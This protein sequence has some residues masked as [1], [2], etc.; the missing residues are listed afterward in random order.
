LSQICKSSRLWNR[1]FLIHIPPPM[2]HFSSDLMANSNVRNLASESGVGGLRSG[3]GALLGCWRREVVQGSIDGCWWRPSADFSRA[4]ILHCKACTELNISCTVS[5]IGCMKVNLD[6]NMV[7]WSSVILVLSFNRCR[8][9]T[10]ANS[11][12]LL[13][14]S[15]FLGG[16]FQ[17]FLPINQP[18][19]RWHS[20]HPEILCRKCIHSDLAWN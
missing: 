20:R 11:F 8:S 12:S 10:A 6:S 2:M 17:S 14:E 19:N 5:K 7:M 9:T 15:P 3:M 16:P 13:R 1:K 4:I 18:R